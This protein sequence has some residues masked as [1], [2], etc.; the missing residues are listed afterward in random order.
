MTSSKQTHPRRK[1]TLFKATTATKYQR[2]IECLK[3][4]GNH[5]LI[6][7]KRAT[8]Q[9]KTHLWEAYKETWTSSKKKKEPANTTTTKI[10]T[11]TRPEDSKTTK[12]PE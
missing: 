1:S 12:D 4:K 3:C 8:E 6:H 2:K 5:K 7:C 11:K 9:E 10:S